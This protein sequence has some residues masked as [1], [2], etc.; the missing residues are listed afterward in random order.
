MV[1]LLLLAAGAGEA[2]Q[3]LVDRGI[4]A[5][6]LWCFPLEADSQ[7]YVYIPGAA[8]LA[9]DAAGRPEFS[10][11]RYV[12]AAGS[13]TASAATITQAAGG[14]ILHFLVLLE[15]PPGMVEAAQ[16]SLRKTLKNDEV[17]LRGPIVFADGRYA[18]VSSILKP[19]GSGTEKALVAGGRASPRWRRF[20]RRSITSCSNCSSSRSRRRGSPKT[21]AA[22]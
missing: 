1:A 21:S 22:D 2:Q 5:A 3:V 14:G 12:V 13:E 9:T 6:D 16:A 8:R 7:T 15:T 18:L 4:R 19:A 10:F 20:S 17:N 11:V